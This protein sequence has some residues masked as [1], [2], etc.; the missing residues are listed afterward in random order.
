MNATNECGPL[1]FRVRQTGQEKEFTKSNYFREQY[2]EPPCRGCC[3]LGHSLLGVDVAPRTRSGKTIYKYL[4]PVV[5]HEDLYAVSPKYPN[6]ELNI[7]YFVIAERYAM[8]H[9]YDIEDC[10][11]KLSILYGGRG[12]EPPPYMDSFIGEF[13][14]VCRIYGQEDSADREVQRIEDMKFDGV[15]IKSFRS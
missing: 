1:A 8:V 7:T 14:R 9:Q 10:L 6:D 5:E 4:C 12:S 13:K 11:N 3:S 15:D 2:L